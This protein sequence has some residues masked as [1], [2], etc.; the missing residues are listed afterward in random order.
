LLLVRSGHAVAVHWHTIAS[1]LSGS[2]TITRS[3]NGGDHFISS[4]AT[5]M[6]IMIRA[7]AQRSAPAQQLPGAEE[8]SALA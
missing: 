7:M 8:I 1:F 3:A 5:S 6:G 2:N 4:M